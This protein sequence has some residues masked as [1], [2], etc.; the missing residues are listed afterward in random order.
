MT[1]KTTRRKVG[2]SPKTIRKIDGVEMFY[3][4]DYYTKAE[5]ERKAENLRGRC[6]RCRARILRSS[7]KVSIYGKGAERKMAW[8]Y[9]VYINAAAAKFR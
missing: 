7:K 6:T 5:A 8:K 3:V 2:A 9:F 1:G 4:D